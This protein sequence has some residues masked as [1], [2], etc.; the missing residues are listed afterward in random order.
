[1]RLNALANNQPAQEAS[2]AVLKRF[3]LIFKAVQQ[4]AHWVEKNCGL[5]NAQLW[6]VWELAQN[7]GI[8]LTELAKIM[9]IHQSTASNLLEKLVKKGLV[10]REKR[11]EDQRVVSLFLTEAGLQVLASAPKPARGILQ[12]AL[13]NLP[14]TTLVSLAKNLDELIEAMGIRDDAAAMQPLAVLAKNPAGKPPAQSSLAANPGV[15][16]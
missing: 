16:E 11:S 2:A 13:F 12:H 3:R 15:A 9:T 7:P 8:R 1:M 10:R 14:D 6:V 5:S 4:H